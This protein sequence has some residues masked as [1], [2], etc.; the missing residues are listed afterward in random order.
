MLK[1][2]DFQCQAYVPN[3]ILKWEKLADAIMPPIKGTK[4]IE[5]VLWVA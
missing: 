4:D 5:N 3:V 2:C 1:N